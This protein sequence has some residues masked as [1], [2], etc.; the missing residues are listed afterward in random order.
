MTAPVP[1]STPSYAERRA[2]D[3]A[4]FASSMAPL[5]SFRDRWNTFSN[6]WKVPIEFA[7]PVGLDYPGF[8]EPIQPL[9]DTLKGM[10]EIELLPEGYLHLTTVHV[11]FLMATDIM[12]SQVE[13]IYVNAAPRLHRLEPFTLR[14]TGVSADEDG[15][16]LGVEDDGIITEIRRLVRLAVPVVYQKARQD[17]HWEDYL[18]KIQVAGFTGRGSRDRVVEAVTPYLEQDITELTV[19]QVKMSRIPADPQ[20]GFGDLDV[21]AEIRLYGAAGR[22]GYHN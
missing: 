14:V 2:Q 18:P 11:G 3:W 6:G 17:A 21:I 16:Y 7:Q 22:M 20:T 10:E 9:L 15:V 13:S 12:W 8:L 19:D 1:E 5:E 4:A